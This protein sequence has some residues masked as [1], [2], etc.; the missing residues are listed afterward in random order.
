MM[1]LV[2]IALGTSTPTELLPGTGARMWIRSALSA[3][4]M[5]LVRPEIR[6]SLTPGAGWSS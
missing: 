6:S 3:A 1:T 5:L 2:L 4:A